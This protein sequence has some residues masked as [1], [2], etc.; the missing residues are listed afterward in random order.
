[1][2]VNHPAQLGRRSRLPGRKEGER[3]QKL[4]VHWRLPSQ[5]SG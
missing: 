3:V 2:F 5:D 4:E 1:M